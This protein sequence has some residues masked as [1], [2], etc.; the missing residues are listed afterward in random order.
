LMHRT[1]ILASIATLLILTFSGPHA[2]AEPIRSQ[3]LLSVSQNIPL[4]EQVIAAKEFTPGV[5][6]WK[7]T[8]KQL[9]GG[10]QT[11]VDLIVL[12]NGRLSV[13]IVPCRGLGIW[14]VTMG[15]MRLGWN[16][17]VREV[18]H[19]QFVNL[20]SRGGLGWLDGFGEFLCRCGL[21]SNGHPGIDTIVD[22]TGAESQVELTL[23]G[24]QAYLP[25]QELTLSV[26][27][28]KP[29]RIRLK[30]RVEERMMHGPKL[31][32]A[33]EVSTVPGSSEFTIADEIMNESGSSSEFQILYHT[34]FGAPLLEA[35]A[36]VIAPWRR[37]QPFNARA[38]EGD[39]HEFATYAAPAPGYVE[40]V[41]CAELYADADHRTAVLLQNRAANH[42]ASLSYSAEAL[43]YLTIWK[44]TA[45]EADG[46][47]T[48]I[49]PGTNFPHNRHHERRFGRV[50]K[51]GAGE[52][53][54]I[55]LN[56]ALLGDAA[57]VS[58][59][60]QRIEAIRG[61]QPIEYVEEPE[62]VASAK[63]PQASLMADFEQA[64]FGSWRVEGDAFGPGPAHGTLAGQQTVSGFTGNHLACSY[65]GGDASTGTLTSPPF[66]LDGPWINLLV[67]GGC[68]PET[69]VELLVD[70]QVVAT[71]TGTAT[72]GADDEHLSWRSWNVEPWRGQ[73]AQIVMRDSH[74]GDWG[75]INVDHIEQ[76]P[77]PRAAAQAHSDLTLAVASVAGAASRASQ[78]A[79]R[80]VFHVAPPALWCNDPNG[81]IYHNGY[82]HL[83][84]QHNPFGDRWEHMHWGHVRSKDLVHWEHLPIA[85]GPSRAQGEDHCFSGC[86][87][88]NS[89]GQVMLFYTSI[90]AR[91][92]E[93][94]AALAADDDLTSF[95]KHPANPILDLSLHGAQQVD[96]WRDPFIF[97]AAGKTFM[98]VGGHRRGGKGAIFLYE[99]A[100]D[101]LGKWN[102]RG[103]AFE[104]EEN[105]WECPNLF[106][107]G[108]RWVL[109]YSPHGPVK[110]YTGQFDPQQGKFTPDDQ[111]VLDASDQ[112]YAPNGCPDP[113]GR[114]LMWGWIRGFPGGRGW[115]GC[116][117]LPRE[118]TIADDGRLVQTPARELAQ[119]RLPAEATP[120]FIAA[121]S[122]SSSRLGGCAALELQVDL[123]RPTQGE[124]GIQLLADG[125][126]PLPIA[127]D[128]KSLRCGDTR[129]AFTSA[130]DRATLRVFVDRSVVEIYTDD[131]TTLTR[132]VDYGQGPWWAEPIEDSTVQLK[133]WPL[134][135]IWQSPRLPTE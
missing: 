107:I 81:P 129:T 34:N 21:E 100:D 36:Q 86:A 15:G 128:G 32:L 12:D 125:K 70:G 119:L 24:K 88:T 30:G 65:H 124:T 120:D 114:W 90:G 130:S 123:S 16:S 77:T 104:G 135:S 26:D 35:G 134:A 93:Q 8:V 19:P 51:L 7:V 20:S 122:T 18:V 97:Q 127:W 11:G 68:H 46:Y 101:R 5:P 131:G 121:S 69:C 133:A 96:D 50:P 10:K 83:F 42:G 23:H 54:R 45:A 117:T 132:V 126:T 95:V 72:T 84:Y 79:A 56:I 62:P 22:N 48:G 99:A 13:Q 89:Q 116:L 64:D 85:L 27:R 91:A 29:H 92:P 4:T 108:D 74:T 105:N 40:Q 115:N 112:F 9:H 87:T 110:Y 59:E 38:A 106:P 39:W 37:V 102:Y 28:E 109:I 113:A 3:T 43:P 75:H 94:W 52:K 118:L 103:I 6:G 66:A 57:A 61:T 58:R 80:P 31:V 111:G 71:A 47:V 44:N 55:E 63:S 98:V 33:T 53:R 73:Q 60:R 82:Y 14:S 67:G 25:A 76:A 41:Y 2:A 49:E 78:D 1:T 17:P